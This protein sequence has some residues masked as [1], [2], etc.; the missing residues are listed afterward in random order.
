MKLGNSKQFLQD[1]L[2]C[3]ETEVSV[4]GKNIS[5]SKEKVF[6]ALIDV[7]NNENS[8]EALK[9]AAIGDLKTILLPYLQ[10]MRTKVIAKKEEVAGYLKGE[11]T[12]A[13]EKGFELFVK[14]LN[15][16]IK[17]IVEL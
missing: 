15:A 6:V 12:T 17:E 14:E 5:V 3:I 9:K 4:S 13:R 10:S 8:S 7:V 16:C 11:Y 2:Y 1:T